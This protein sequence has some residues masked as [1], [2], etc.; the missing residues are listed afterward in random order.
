M[1]FI[2]YFVRLCCVEHSSFKREKV[3]TSMTS[4]IFARRTLSH[5]S[6]YYVLKK[7]TGDQ[8]FYNIMLLIHQCRLI[9]AIFDPFRNTS[10]MLYFIL[11]P[12]R[13]ILYNHCLFVLTYSIATLSVLFIY[14]IYLYCIGIPMFSF[15]VS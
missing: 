4:A 11:Y 14:C 7:S 2:E 6:C 5:G 9:S 8:L 13:H 3:K 12:F 10:V 1:L 15:K